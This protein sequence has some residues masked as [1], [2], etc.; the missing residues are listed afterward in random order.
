MKLKMHSFDFDECLLT[1]RVPQNVMWNSRFGN[2]LD[3][4]EVDMA[5]ITNNV[6]LG[7]AAPATA[8]LICECGDHI[9]GDYAFVNGKYLCPVCMEGGHCAGKENQSANSVRDAIFP[10]LESVLQYS[11]MGDAKNAIIATRQAMERLHSN[12]ENT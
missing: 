1:F 5:A 11:I 10:L 4:V 3:G 9:T 7:I 8:Q 2:V 6:A 12:N